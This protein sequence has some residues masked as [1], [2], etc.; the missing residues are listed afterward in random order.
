MFRSAMLI[1][2]NNS[3]TFAFRCDA[4]SEIGSGHVMRCLTLANLLQSHGHK[5]FFLCTN[6]TITTVPFLKDSGF[7]VKAP[8]DVTR[9][10]WLIIDHYGLDI[11]YEFQAR[12]W[13]KKICVIDDLADRHHDCDLLIDQTFDRQPS[14][15]QNLVPRSAQVITGSNF[16][17]LRPEFQKIRD[18]LSRNFTNPHR[19]LITFGGVNPKRSTQLILEALLNYQTKALYIDVV[20]SK[21]AHDLSEIES[22]EKQYHQQ[23]LHQVKLHLSTS[24]MANLMADADLCIGAGGTTSWERCCLKLPT[25][26][27]EVA[28]NQR[29]ILQ[30]LDKAG[31]LLY[32]DNI[33]NFNKAVFTEKFNAILSSSKLCVMAEKA[34]AVCDGKGAARVAEIMECA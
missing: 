26:A 11:G 27:Y 18:N 23:N 29:F 4:S 12:K 10:D 8:E 3:Q 31:A 28:N 13:T 15:Y 1:R 5:I 9:T 16:S 7:T 19:V 17:I 20:L 32:V 25:M 24:L 14:S 34:A 33:V 2:E 30:N 6:E 21:N 22:L